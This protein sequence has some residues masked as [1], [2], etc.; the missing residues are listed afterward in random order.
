MRNMGHMLADAMHNF[1]VEKRN[2]AFC[3]I[4]AREIKLFVG[5]GNISV[6]ASTDNEMPMN[7]K[8]TRVGVI[9]IKHILMR[10]L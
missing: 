1:K 9:P 2:F 5:V 4:F 8:N 6:D 7:E 10:H 3:S